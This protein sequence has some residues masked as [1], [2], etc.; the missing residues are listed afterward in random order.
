MY[1]DDPNLPC[2]PRKY[3]GLFTWNNSNNIAVMS[4]RR[5]N[6]ECWR[7]AAFLPTQNKILPVADIDIFILDMNS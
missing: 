4:G 2:G 3:G 1:T 6:Y 7:P 5:R